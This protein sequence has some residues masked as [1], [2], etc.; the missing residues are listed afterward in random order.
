MG[1]TSATEQPPVG[2][3]PVQVTVTDDLRR[4]RWTVVVRFL[5]AIPLYLWLLL[6]AIAVVFAVVANWFATLITGRSPE[7][8]YNFLTAFVRFATHLHAYVSLA[9]NPYPSFTGEPGYPVDVDFGPSL[10][11]NRWVTGFRIILV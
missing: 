10:P 6:W 2:L 4:N 3:H 5:L 1:G 7:P 9:A 8:L 11:Q